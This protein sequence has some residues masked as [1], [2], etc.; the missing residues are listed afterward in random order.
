[1]EIVLLDDEPVVVKDNDKVVLDNVGVG[2]MAVVK[3]DVGIGVGG[4][5]C[6]LVDFIVVATVEVDAVAVVIVADVVV[7]ELHVFD[8]VKHN[9]N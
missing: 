1:M 9:K 7:A 4:R 2:S 3:E 5:V 6:R 8:T